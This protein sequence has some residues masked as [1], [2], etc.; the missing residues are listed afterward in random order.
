MR[1][2]G[3]GYL[4]RS[5]SPKPE[6]PASYND[7]GDSLPEEEQEKARTQRM[8]RRAFLGTSAAYTAGI[9]GTAAVTTGPK[10][11]QVLEGVVEP[12]RLKRQTAEA[13]ARVKE[14]YGI[15]VTFDAGEWE[16]STHSEESWLAEK[17]DAIASL[18]VSLKK[19]PDW[20]IREQGLGA[21]TLRSNLTFREKETAHGPVTQLL[22]GQTR[23]SKTRPEIIVDVSGHSKDDY[24]SFGWNDARKFEENFSHEFFHSIEALSDTWW[25]EKMS[26]KVTYLRDLASV[27]SAE[28]RKGFATPYGMQSE[29]EDKA[30]IYEALASDNKKLLKQCADD[31]VLARKVDAVK[32]YMSM[33]SYG[34]MNETY[35]NTR[36]NSSFSDSFF[37]ERAAKVLKMSYGT[38]SK[39]NPHLREAVSAADF[40]EWKEKLIAQYFPSLA[41]KHEKSEVYAAEP[42][43]GI[44]SEK[45]RAK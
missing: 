24:H 2:G 11:V 5:R 41:R 28:V 37:R 32:A 6:S 42:V 40:E 20:F 26:S 31:P 36:N 19:Y 43:V 27:K 8:S 30:T 33:K 10:L 4:G 38:F 39:E 18:E 23:K 22:E 17:R 25:K 14:R 34:L 13:V 3:E 7:A 1:S 45:V 12:E 44:D 15:P 29:L 16:K 21:I 9:V 35:W